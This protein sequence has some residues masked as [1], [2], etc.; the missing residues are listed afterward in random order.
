MQAVAETPT[1]DAHVYLMRMYTERLQILVSKDQRRQ[2]EREAKRRGSSVA[3]VIRGAVETQLGGV[4]KEDRLGAV[5]AIAS[6]KGA[7]YL[8][9]EELA[10]EI[11]EARGEEI[12]RGLPG[13]LG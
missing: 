9:P 2:L 8:P 5:R 13:G 6:M 3:S 1:A 4:A 12:D 7:P 10:R 11:D